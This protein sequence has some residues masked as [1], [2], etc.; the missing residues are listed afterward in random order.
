MEERTQFLQKHLAFPP[1]KA[2]IRVL[3]SPHQRIN[4]EL[5]ALLT[6]LG[7]KWLVQLSLHMITRAPIILM[8]SPTTASVSFYVT[9]A[10]WGTA[11]LGHRYV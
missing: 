5:V 8:L 6:T 11:W 4:V 2:V 3:P 7:K 9:I 10:T 1:R